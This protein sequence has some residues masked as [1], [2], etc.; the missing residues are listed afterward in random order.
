LLLVE[1]LVEDT[2]VETTK[3]Q[4]AVVAV[5]ELAVLRSHHKTTL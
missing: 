3:A 4:V 2:V 1:V 5:L